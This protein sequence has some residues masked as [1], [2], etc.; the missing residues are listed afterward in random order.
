MF[1]QKSDP[2]GVL[3]LERCTVE[4][5][6]NEQQDFSFVIGKLISFTTQ[7]VNCNKIFF[8]QKPVIYYYIPLD[9]FSK[10]VFT[11]GKT[12]LESAVKGLNNSV[13]VTCIQCLRV[14]KRPTHSVPKRKKNE[15]AGFSV[16]MMPAMNV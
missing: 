2:Q 6:P 15:M 5:D 9:K 4:L 8:L 7:A 1:F 14:K 13:V 10:N 16:C 3:V 11:K 12:K